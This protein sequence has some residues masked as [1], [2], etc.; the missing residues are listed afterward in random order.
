M[1]IINYHQF[2]NAVGTRGGG[3]CCRIRVIVWQTEQSKDKKEAYQSIIQH[4]IPKLLLPQKVSLNNFLYAKLSTSM[5]Y[6]NQS[7]NQTTNKTSL[8]EDGWPY[9]KQ[10]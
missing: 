7:V 4:K 6:A 2:T 1:S 5:K 3:G 9:L 8:L 10:V